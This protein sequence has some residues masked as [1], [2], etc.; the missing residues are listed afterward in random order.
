MSPS[1]SLSPSPASKRHV[2]TRIARNDTCAACPN[3]GVSEACRLGR[4]P[5]SA[6]ACN[7]LRAGA[8]ISVPGGSCAERSP[9][10]YQQ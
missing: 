4:H 3:V 6:L 10:G 8:L 1:A 7:G 5:S 2:A 9:R